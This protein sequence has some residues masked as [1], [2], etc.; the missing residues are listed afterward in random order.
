MEPNLVI[1]VLQ[2]LSRKQKN[3]TKK[4]VRLSESKCYCH[5]VFLFLMYVFFCFIIER[6]PA[7]CDQ[8]IQKKKAAL[9][10]K[11]DMLSRQRAM[12]RCEKKEVVR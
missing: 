2:D 10:Q 3:A 8:D 9:D 4:F 5:V 1:F 12:H 6:K 7:D 11:L